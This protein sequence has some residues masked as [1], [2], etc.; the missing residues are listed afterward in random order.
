MESNF[1]INTYINNEDYKDN[2]DKLKTNLYKMGILLKDYPDENL[3]LLYNRYDNKNKGP[4][5]LECRSV[6]LNRTT[7]DI[8]CYT[9]PTPIYNMDALNY[10]VSNS[11]NNKKIFKCYEGSLL[12]LYYF[13]NKWYLSSRKC[14]HSKNSIINN[15]SHYDMFLEV[16]KLDNF[17]SFEDFTDKLDK[18]LTYHFVLI[19]YENQNIVNYKLEFGNEYKKLCFIFARD[20]IVHKEIDSEDVDSLI[21]SENIF[22]PKK[23]HD[24]LSFDKS[25]QLNDISEQPIEEGIVIKINNNLLKLQTIS[26]QFYKV[27][28][29]EKNLYRGFL[30][31][32]QTNKLKDYFNNY[33]NSEK[34]KKIVNPLNTTQSFDTIGIIDAVFKVC[35]SELFNLF[36]ILWA[37]NVHMNEELYKILP[38]EYKN[39]LFHI[40]GINNK[41]KKKNSTYKVRVQNIYNYLKMI[42]TNNFENFFK[43]RKLMMNWVRLEPEN[44][45]LKTFYK[46]LYHCDKVYYKLSAIY[47]NKLF[48]E[49]MPND[50]PDKINL[51]KN[52][53]LF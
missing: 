25:N 44:T 7:F 52:E 18:K 6:V 45:I 39:I 17:S 38:K 3:I 27:I 1:L 33:S 8:V 48:P 51:K 43:C 42:E 32:Y 26:Y 31:L 49:I 5:E 30:R 12:S 11:E 10:L 36:N 20:N 21:L 2:I 15:K 37:E 19:H 41:L 53:I 29:P 40:R 46:S 9:C 22:L 50:I 35:T 16:L 47:S 13:N 24:E 23:L 14:L 4:I 34:Y 28:G